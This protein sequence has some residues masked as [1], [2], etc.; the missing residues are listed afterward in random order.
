MKP[1]EPQ[2][3]LVR[4]VVAAELFVL[5][6]YWAPVPAGGATLY[7]FACLSLLVVPASLLALVLAIV[8]GIGALVE[9]AYQGR[10][11][12]RGARIARWSIAAI[13]L[14]ALLVGLFWSGTPTVFERSLR[15]TVARMDEAVE[16]LIVA[17][18]EHEA[19]NGS[20]PLPEEL[21]TS[22]VPGPSPLYPEI[23]YESGGD[24]WSLVAES[25]E[26]LF[27]G[28]LVHGHNLLTGVHVSN[29]TYHDW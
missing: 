23:R 7:Y 27:F 24:G 25:T 20:W 28:W 12:V 29:W 3:T 8:A 4:L 18:R 5:F 6:V 2:W 19:R 10:P 9:V 14:F 15:A 22:V 11:L 26:P 16:P 21:E 17:V 1:T 13:A